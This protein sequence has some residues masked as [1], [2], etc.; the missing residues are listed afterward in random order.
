VTTGSF[1]S[2]IAAG[3]GGGGVPEPVTWATMLLGFGGIGLAARR[4]R[5]K[6][7]PALG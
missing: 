1:A 6:S 4:A 2:D 7:A 3:G 5:R